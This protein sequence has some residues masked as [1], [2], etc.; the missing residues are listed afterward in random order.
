MKVVIFVYRGMTLL[1]AIGPY[2]VLRNLKDVEILFVSKDGKP[3]TADSTFLEINPKYQIENITKA[4]ILLIPGAPVGYLR[5][6]KDKRILNWIKQIHPQT[7]RTTSVCTGS[8]IL[9]AAGLLT[10]K[11][12]TSHWKTIQQL[13]DYGAIPIRERVV[14]EG[15]IITAAGVSAG[16]DMALYLLHTL[17]GE[18]AAK[19]AQLAIEYD[20][21]PIFDSGNFLTAEKSVIQEAERKMKIAAKK[22]LTLMDLLRNIGPLLKMRNY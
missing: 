17:E 13:S 16:I 11:K 21:K 14:E 22:E 7:L 15:K 1:D 19:A 9:A 4:D 6:L 5:I 3:V 8:I 18:V 2:E 12:A 20:P 10:D